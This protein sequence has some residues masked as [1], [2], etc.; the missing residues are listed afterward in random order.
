MIQLRSEYAAESREN[1]LLRTSH[2]HI[3]EWVNQCR[4]EL[5]SLRSSL[6]KQEEEWGQA[7]SALAKDIAALADDA[8]S[9]RNRNHLQL[10]TLQGKLSTVL[11][12]LEKQRNADRKSL[13][14]RL[15]SLEN[16]NRSNQERWRLSIS[17]LHRSQVSWRSVVEEKLQK[18]VTQ[19]QQDHDEAKKACSVI[20][21]KSNDLQRI[22]REQAAEANR[23]YE[24]TSQAI[25]AFADVLKVSPP[26]S[27]MS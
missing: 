1:R 23:Q 7:S 10:E 4:T 8:T 11:D 27:S 13:D 22:I 25:H 24:A 18:V 3:S 5:V 21:G 17:E 26:L 19:A 2:T 20:V 14:E 12:S 15:A 16:I 9:I 6:H